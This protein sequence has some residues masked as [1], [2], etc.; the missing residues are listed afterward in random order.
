MTGGCALGVYETW[1]TVGTLEVNADAW[2]L[3]VWATTKDSDKPNNDT[4]RK[5]SNF[6]SILV[7]I[8]NL[9]ALKYCA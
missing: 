3:A 1:A 8:I 5:C 2:V 7:V 9:V 6:I 4:R